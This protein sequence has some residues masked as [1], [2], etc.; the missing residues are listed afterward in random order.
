MN[1]LAGNFKGSV[2]VCATARCLWDDLAQLGPWTGDVAAVNHA[3]MA[4]PMPYQHLCSLETYVLQ[5]IL[6]LAK[7]RQ[8]GHIWIHGPA[9]W[10]EIVQ[11]GGT[12][13]MFAVQVALALGY[14]KVVLAG[15]PLDGTGHFYDPPGQR[16]GHSYAGRAIYHGWEVLRERHRDRIT[17]LSGQT[18]EWFGSPLDTRGD[19]G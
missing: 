2:L 8:P 12:S 3:G 19:M 1:V 15:A 9:D 4:L 14:D 6:E 10:P 5:P 13:T 7:L 11:R 17:S 18:R 16:S